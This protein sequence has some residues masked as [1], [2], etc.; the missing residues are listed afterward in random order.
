MTWWLAVCALLA[1]LFAFVDLRSTHVGIG[2]G[3]SEVG[4]LA[5]KW[6]L[7][8]LVLINVA[9]WLVLVLGGA[10]LPD[11]APRNACLLVLLLMAFGHAY[12]WDGNAR[13]IDNAQARGTRRVG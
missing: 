4:K 12:V 3:L 7:R 11:P 5:R 8:T 6:G 2:L 9:G 13:K 1:G 10:L